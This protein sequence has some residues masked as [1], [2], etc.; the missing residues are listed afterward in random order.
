MK[1]LTVSFLISLAFFFLIVALPTKAQEPL[2]ITIKPD[3]SVEPT[4]D[5]LERNGNTYTFKGDIYGT[6]RVQTDDII[7]DGAGH[8]LQGYGDREDIYLVGPDSSRPHCV[9]V[10]VENL[11]LR[12]GVIRTAGAS[13]HS[14]IGN[15]FD[16]SGIQ[17]Q[18]GGNGTGN[19]VKHN[20]FRH[21]WV[22]YDYNHY[23]NDIFIENNFLDSRIFIG[24]AVQPHAD[25]NYWDNYTINYPNAKEVDNSGV[26][27]TPYVGTS[28][29]GKQ[30]VDY[31]PLVNPVTE[32][33]LDP[34][35]PHPTPTTS[36]SPSATATSTATAPASDAQTINPTLLLAIIIAVP[37]AALAVA[38]IVARKNSPKKKP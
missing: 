37:L 25:Y 8:T 31:Y 30:C 36:A 24:I 34:N 26:W 10:L 23:G 38:A 6:I 3:G 27:D 29:D 14:F 7:I 33:I 16:N 11:R 28:F 12:D 17:M 13:N 4:T 32:G 21:G 1:V 2:D 18:F 35:N 15:Y 20:T 9:N 19:I 5:L 22:F